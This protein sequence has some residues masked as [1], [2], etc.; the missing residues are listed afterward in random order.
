MTGWEVSYCENV[1]KS[2]KNHNS[3]STPL[4]KC[5]KYRGSFLFAAI[6]TALKTQIERSKTKKRK[7]I[8]FNILSGKLGMRNLRPKEMQSQT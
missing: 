8:V 5:K 2:K 4:R 7:Y 6:K 3:N 1:G